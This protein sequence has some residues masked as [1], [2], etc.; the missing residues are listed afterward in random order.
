MQINI[1]ILPTHAP[2]LT[3]MI[4]PLIFRGIICESAA[5]RQ[6]RIRSVF[7]CD[8]RNVTLIN[9][10]SQ[11]ASISRPF[12][13][14]VNVWWRFAIRASRFTSISFRN[15][16]WIERLC[17]A[18]LHPWR[19]V[20]LR[21]NWFLHWMLIYAYGWRHWWWERYLNIT[22]RYISFFAWQVVDSRLARNWVGSVLCCRIRKPVTGFNAILGI[23]DS[24]QM[25][26]E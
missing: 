23:S 1:R 14:S 8:S 3:V 16:S 24:H 6:R 19:I 21:P 10:K 2:C 26:G 11:I 20:R 17:V 15:S 5:S 7:S 4:E 18:D 22:E 9:F 25:V 12:S 13:S